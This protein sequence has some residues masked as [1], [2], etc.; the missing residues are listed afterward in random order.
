MFYLI[1][2]LDIVFFT[3][4]AQVLK[5]CKERT[6]FGLWYIVD[7]IVEYLILFFNFNL[8]SFRSSFFNVDKI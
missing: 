5:F 8:F 1:K 6:Y 4:R 7:K 3:K 2:I